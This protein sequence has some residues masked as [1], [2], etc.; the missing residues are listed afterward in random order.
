M[1]FVVPTSLEQQDLLTLHRL[2]ARLINERT[3]LCRALTKLG[4]DISL[5]RRRRRLKR[6]STISLQDP[7]ELLSQNLAVKPIKAWRPS[8][9]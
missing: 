3:A 1:T 7:H 2:G 8:R 9:S 4:R 6:S 5:T